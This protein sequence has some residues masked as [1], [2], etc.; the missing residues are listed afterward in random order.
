M[1]IAYLSH[2]VIEIIGVNSDIVV[3]FRSVAQFLSYFEF[4]S[5]YFCMMYGLSM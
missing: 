1:V 3:G 5:V 4:L 2:F